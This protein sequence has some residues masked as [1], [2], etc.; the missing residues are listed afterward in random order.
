MSNKYNIP[1]PAKVSYAASIDPVSNL[2]V[3]STGQLYL[4][5]PVKID[6]Q[7]LVQDDPNAQPMNATDAIV[8]PNTGKVILPTGPPTPVT[9]PTGTTYSTGSIADW[10]KANP[11]MAAGAAAIIIYL[12]THK[13][14]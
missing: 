2:S 7:T 1:H 6:T 4:G 8:D 5:P 13:R 11:L 10:I 14:K 3:D 12:L 9:P